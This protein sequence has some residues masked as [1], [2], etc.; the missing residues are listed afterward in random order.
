ME[1]DAGICSKT[2]FFFRGFL[3]LCIETVHGPV[4]TDCRESLDAFDYLVADFRHR[5]PFL[6]A[7]RTDYEIHL[8]AFLEIVADADA[9]P[10]IFGGFQKFLDVLQSVMSAVAAFLAH[11]QCPERQDHVIT[12]DNEIFHRDA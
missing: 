5:L 3:Y 11:A 10:W 2:I 6:L 8:P 1:F 12:D 9:D 7:H 4:R